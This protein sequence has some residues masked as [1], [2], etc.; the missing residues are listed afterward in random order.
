MEFYE[1]NQYRLAYLFSYLYRLERFNTIDT[2]LNKKDKDKMSKLILKTCASFITSSSTI[3]YFKKYF[4][5][6]I[7]FENFLSELIFFY[8]N[9]T[10]LGTKIF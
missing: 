1:I 9:Q 4:V 6:W 7:Y 8:N 5:Y 10:V 3:V 2:C